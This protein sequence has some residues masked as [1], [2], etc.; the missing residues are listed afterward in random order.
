MP[1]QS[2]KLSEEAFD[3]QEDDVKLEIDLEKFA[4]TKRIQ[5]QLKPEKK[6]TLPC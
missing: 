3:A 4:E 6:N 5:R 1:L 2:E